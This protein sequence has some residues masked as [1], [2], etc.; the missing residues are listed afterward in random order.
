MVT[1]AEILTQRIRRTIASLRQGEDITVFVRR[2][3]EELHFRGL[4]LGSTVDLN[5]IEWLDL[6]NPGHGVMGLEIKDIYAIERHNTF[7]LK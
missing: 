6:E 1:F 2:L 4:Y 5:D 7:T 3:P